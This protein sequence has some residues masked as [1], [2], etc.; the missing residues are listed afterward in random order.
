[1]TI[2]KTERT[3]RLMKLLIHLIGHT[4]CTGYAIALTDSQTLS[5]SCFLCGMTSF[6]P[7]DVAQKY[8]GACQVFHDDPPALDAVREKAD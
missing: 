3:E 8:C 6:N 5:I 4:T 1:M 7:T 2:N